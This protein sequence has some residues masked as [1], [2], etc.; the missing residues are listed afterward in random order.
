MNR[1]DFCHCC[2]ALR[3]VA[4]S[5]ARLFLS[6]L[7][8]IQGQRPMQRGAGRLYEQSPQL[9]VHISVQRNGGGLADR[10]HICNDCL[11]VG[12]RHALKTLSA[13][14]EKPTD[15]ALRDDYPPPSDTLWRM[16]TGGYSHEY[17][18]QLGRDS[19]DAQALVRRAVSNWR[20][21]NAEIHADPTQGG[22]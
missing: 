12:V 4:A 10:E 21:I 8:E 5:Q 17:I 7:V 15:Y 2:G 14:N 9:S 22:A 20:Q 19:G 11:L 13:L 16:L 18:E 1:L 3:G 6:D